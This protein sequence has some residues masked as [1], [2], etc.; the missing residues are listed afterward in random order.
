MVYVDLGSRNWVGR[1]IA[2]FIVHV[3]SF[4]VMARKNTDKL[5]PG[6]TVIEADR[7]NNKSVIQDTN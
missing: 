5:T 4:Y 6:W 7:L 1:L 2:L 3:W